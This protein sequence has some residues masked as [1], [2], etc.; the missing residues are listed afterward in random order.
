MVAVHAPAPGVPPAPVVLDSP[1]SGTDY[2]DDFR[3]AVSL[4]V[5][6]GGEDRFVD[7]LFTDAPRHGATLIAAEVARTYIDLNRTRADIDTSLLCD[8]WDP[9]RD[10]P[11]LPSPH[12][13]RGTGLVFRE[14][15]DGVPIYDRALTVAEV[16]QRIARAWDPY[17]TALAGAL[18]AAA[19]RFG[20]VWHLNCHSMMPVG[21][22]L[23][24]D[25]G[26]RRPD[27]VLGDRDG[28]TCDGA[29][30]AFVAD[31]LTGMGY[32]V[33]VNTPYKGAAIVETCGRPAEGRHS[34]Q[35]EINRALYMDIDTL[36]RHGGFPRLRDAMDRLAA[37]LCAWARS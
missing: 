29:Y 22:A 24:P 13:A 21:N 18:D 11:L 3:P 7:A 2:P 6:R 9:A 23:S 17:H 32:S 28:T 12:S 14:I 34:L 31:T 25:P 19:A 20:A 37:A 27:F 26:V 16:K 30:T 5:L 4:E 8:Q 15:G 1:H 35:I 10:G 36:E 33:A